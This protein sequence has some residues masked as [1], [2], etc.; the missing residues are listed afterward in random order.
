[1]RRSRRTPVRLDQE[2]HSA[3]NG[4][5]VEVARDAEHVAVRDSKHPNGPVLLF[6]ATA[7]HHVTRTR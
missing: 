7:F 1:M 3:N 2:Q 6:A 4:N 5:Y